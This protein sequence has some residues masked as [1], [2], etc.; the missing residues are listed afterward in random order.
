MDL[1][2][3]HFAK[4]ALLQ[5]QGPGAVRALQHVNTEIASR[6]QYAASLHQSVDHD[7]LM[8]AVHGVAR[9][10]HWATV[11]KS[12]LATAPWCIA[13]D[14][15]DPVTHVGLQVHHKHCS[16]HVAILLGLAYLEL[17]SRNLCVL[18]ETEAGKDAPNHHLEIGHAGDFRRDCNPF[19]DDDAVTFRGM[20]TDAIKADP[21]Y[22]AHVAA[23]PPDWAEWTDD[24]KIAKRTELLAKFPPDPT[25]LAKYGL[26]TPDLMRMWLPS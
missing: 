3:L 20:S 7:A 22:L 6:L 2:S 21:R 18:G 12:I 16:F 1:L 25:M 5:Q 26:P 13:C 15:N 8:G 4:H 17:D 11:E 14:P 24:M 9:S 19:I 10:T 23:A